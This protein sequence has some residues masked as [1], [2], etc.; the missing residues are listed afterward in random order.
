MEPAA[1]I[2]YGVTYDGNYVNGYVNGYA[3]GEYL[4]GRLWE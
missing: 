3:K 1:H 4:E 2:L